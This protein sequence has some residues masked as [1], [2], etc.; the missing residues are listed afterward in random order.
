[1]AGANHLDDR[2]CDAAPDVRQAIEA[3]DPIAVGRSAAISAAGTRPTVSAALRYAATRL[4]NWAP[5]ARNRFRDFTQ[6]I[7]KFQTRAI[8][9]T[10]RNDWW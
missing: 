4:R 2:G 3:F 10:G 8:P 9:D 7:G 5:C 6:A 1:V